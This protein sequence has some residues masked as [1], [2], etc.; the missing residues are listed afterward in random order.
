[1]YNEEKILSK[2][3]YKL[4]NYFINL[5]NFHYDWNIII[6]DNASVDNTQKIG[7]KL[8]KLKRVKY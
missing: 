8:E 1:V 6:A 5:N 4:Q 2:S 7:T 3:I